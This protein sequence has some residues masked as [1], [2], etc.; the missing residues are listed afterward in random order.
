MVKIRSGSCILI[1][2]RS[3]ALGCSAAATRFIATAV[4]GAELQ[5]TVAGYC[6]GGR[7][8][9]MPETMDWLYSQYRGQYGVL[10]SWGHRNPLPT[11]LSSIASIVTRDVESSHVLCRSFSRLASY[12]HTHTHTWVYSIPFVEWEECTRDREANV[13]KA[14]S[15]RE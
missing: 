10:V 6:H 7:G 2:W 11:D 12:T 9:V 15:S 4:R 5:H 13:S 8:I 14:W 1:E 3:P